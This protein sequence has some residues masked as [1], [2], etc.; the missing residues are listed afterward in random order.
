MEKSVHDN[1]IVGYE[2]QCERR[3]VRLFT[4][5]RDGDKLERT[6]VVFSGVE[7]YTFRYDCMGNIIFDIE[8]VSA[9]SIVSARQ[10]EFAEGH[11]LSGWPR[12]WR[13]SLDE[14]YKYL[15]EQETRGFEL[16]SS[17]GMDGWVIARSMEI[18]ED[19]RVA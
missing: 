15:R 3:E 14:V 17:Y 1:F 8:E 12:F 10:A 11:R 5:Y 6:V 4:E 2:V 16:S 19:D 9:E 7:A 18:R 13:D